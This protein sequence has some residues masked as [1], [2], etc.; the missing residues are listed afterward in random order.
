MKFEVA[1][2]Y[3]LVPSALLPSANIER[4]WQYGRRY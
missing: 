1:E 4:W 2:F 3:I